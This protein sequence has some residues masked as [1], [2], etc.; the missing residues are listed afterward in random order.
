MQGLA[1][2]LG[3]TQS[4]HTNSY[5]EALGL[6]T[7]ESALLALR[8]Q[9]VIA[10]E[11]GVA[12]TADPLAGSYFVESLTNDLEALAVELISRVDEKGGAVA[13]IEEGWP[14][15]QIEESAYQEARR[16]A[17]GESIVVGVNKYQVDDEPEV[18][19][20]AVDP[21]LERGQRERLADWRTARDAAATEKKLDDLEDAARGDG[22]LL[23]PIKE[24]LRVGATVGEVSA[25]MKN[26]FGGYR[27]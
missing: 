7:D 2:V 8:T 14:Q 11:S 13:A 12:D 4:L 1:A 18:P 26:L 17:V 22:N 19:V 5:D 6:P 10:G 27:P 24:A 3:G 25:R 15:S 21:A 23:P 9:Q 20:L 16:Q